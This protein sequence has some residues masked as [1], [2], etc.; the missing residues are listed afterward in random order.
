MHYIDYGCDVIYIYI[1]IYPDPVN[2][3]SWLIKKVFLKKCDETYFLKY[4]LYI[5]IYFFIFKNYF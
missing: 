2:Q 5:K 3:A 1:Y 4:F